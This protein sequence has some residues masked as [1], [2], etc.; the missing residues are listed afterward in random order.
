MIE[1]QCLDGINYVITAARS[2]SGFC[3][4]WTCECGSHG[5]HAGLFDTEEAAIQQAKQ[6]LLYHHKAAH[7]LDRS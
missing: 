6:C 5:T 4:G 2:G 3:G 7:A 1:R